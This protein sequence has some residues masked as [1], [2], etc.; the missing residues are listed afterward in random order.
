[1]KLYR[2]I[3]VLIIAMF[4]LSTNV[5]AEPYYNYTYNI[6]GIPQKEPEACRPIK[7]IT[8]DSLGINDFNSPS[9]LFVSNKND[10]VF[11]TDTENNRIIVIS[12]KYKFLKEIISFNNNGVTETFKTPRGVFETPDGEIY[13]ADSKKQR[14]VVLDKDYNFIKILPRP[15]SE[16][17]SDN[18]EYVPYA[19]A[20]DDA[21]RVFIISKNVNQGI[22]ELDRDGN[23]VGFFGPI[24]VSP[25]ATDVLWKLIA[26][27][28]QRKLLSQSVPTEYSNIDI[29][30]EGFVYGT[31]S[32]MDINDIIPQ[33]FIRRL[34]PIGIDV[35]KRLGYTAP[36]GDVYFDTDKDNNPNI[37]QLSDIAV[38]EHGKY[39][40]LD[41]RKG[42]I[43]SYTDQGEL[44]Y[45]FGG[46]GNNFGQFGNPIAIDSID[47]NN[48]LVL[49]STYNQI[50]CFCLT[51]YGKIISNAVNDYYNRDL[52]SSA[53][54]WTEALKHTSK[55][56]LA[57]KGFGEALIRNKNYKEAMFYLHIAKDKTNYSL[58][59]QSYRSKVVEKYMQYF[60]SVAVF[61]VVTI[62][63]LKKIR[64]YNRAKKL[65]NK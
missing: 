60:L 40:A 48:F 50:V 3:F 16:L 6:N 13:I 10:K 37:S 31:V 49:D 34:N 33:N 45:V 19:V 30:S 24:I 4:A 32:A 58:A 38:L 36:M 21:K 28:E 11:I 63:I 5:F 8:G 25:K 1:M 42:R 18:F 65:R 2:K 61:L 35:L 55:S 59:F 17:L 27:K 57:F 14:I 51:D 41:K 56:G 44:M 7:V 23:F 62:F 9:D 46:Y 22:I 47:D 43:F 39:L 54:N 64:K 26:S 29:D 20:V 15:I 12:K 52:V 53:K